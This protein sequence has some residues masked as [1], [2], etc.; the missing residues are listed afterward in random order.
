M[1][2]ASAGPRATIAAAAAAASAC[3]E[4]ARAI[5]PARALT[6]ACA[7]VLAAGAAGGCSPGG[8]FRV[9]RALPLSA[10]A[11]SG[12][13]ARPRAAWRASRGRWTRSLKVNTR[14]LA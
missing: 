9:G 2:S 11:Q 4:G 14:Q 6:G 5:L 10:R 1:N 7:D 3:G 13:V 12:P 8:L